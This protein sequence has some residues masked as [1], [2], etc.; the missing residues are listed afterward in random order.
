MEKAS[1]LYSEKT[2]KIIKKVI[3]LIEREFKFF[4]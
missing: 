1:K 4:A 2:P 3:A